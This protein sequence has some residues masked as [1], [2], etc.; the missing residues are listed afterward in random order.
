MPTP[1]A[2]VMVLSAMQQQGLEQIVRQTT[3]PYRLVRRAQLVLSASRGC[4]NS[5]IAQQLNLDRGQVR[6]WHTRWLE[7]QAQMSATEAESEAETALRGVI[8]AVFQDEA[9]PGTPAQFN[10]EQVVQIVAPYL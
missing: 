7:A 3:N 2:S 4:T 6:Y 8:V 10:L 9:R 1:E 5:E